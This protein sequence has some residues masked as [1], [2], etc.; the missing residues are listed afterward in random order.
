MF[1]DSESALPGDPR[2]Q[3]IMFINITNRD[4]A[5]RNDRLSAARLSKISV[6]NIWT[7][8][9]KFEDIGKY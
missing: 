7:R 5:R 1:A 2:G 8:S 4:S 3:A 6:K 9:L